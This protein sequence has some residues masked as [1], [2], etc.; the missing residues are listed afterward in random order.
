M[1]SGE[2]SAASA[3]RPDSQRM[4]ACTLLAFSVMIAAMLPIRALNAA[5]FIEFYSASSERQRTFQGETDL[6]AAPSLL[7]AIIS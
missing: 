7:A 2:K 5:D 1:Q 6:A 4:P 3:M